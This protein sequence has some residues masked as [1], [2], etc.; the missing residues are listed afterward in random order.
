MGN[1]IY[2]DFEIRGSDRHG[3]TVWA[4]VCTEGKEWAGVCRPLHGP[5][6]TREEAVTVMPENTVA[7]ETE[8]VIRG[9]FS[10]IGPGRPA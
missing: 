1:L 3:W 9:G 8:R 6:K 5:F 10:K 4:Y 7:A 2:S